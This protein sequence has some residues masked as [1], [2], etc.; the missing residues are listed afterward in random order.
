MEGDWSRVSAVE[1]V[2]LVVLRDP[3]P[4]SQVD[5]QLRVHGVAALAALPGVR[6]AYAG[7]RGPEQNGERVI[8][9]VWQ[10]QEAV[11]GVGDRDCLEIEVCGLDPAVE[12][13]SI[14]VLPLE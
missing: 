9:S 2:R 4:M 5:G 11:R 8:A 14:D 6:N 7:R 10:S 12:R 1:I 3:A 13:L